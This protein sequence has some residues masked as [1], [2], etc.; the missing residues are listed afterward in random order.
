MMLVLSLNPKRQRRPNVRLGEIGN[1]SASFACGFPPKTKGKLGHKKWK[2][3]FVNQEEI[4]HDPICGF[5]EQRSPKYTASEP[6]FSLKM[7]AD[8]QQNRENK[9]PNSTK[10]ASE[11]ASSDECDMAKSGLDFG[12]ITR[13]CRVMKRRCRN[14]R[15]NNSVFYTAWSSKLNA[16]FD[17]EDAREFGGKECIGFESNTYTNHFPDNGFKDFLDVETPA[18]GKEAREYDMCEPVSDTGQPGYLSQDCNEDACS[19]GNNAFPESGGVWDEM[20]YGGNDVHSVKRWLEELGFGKYA[21]VFEMHEVDE[22]ALLLLTLEDL[23]EMG[24]FAVGPRRKLYTAIQQL[25]G[26][27]VSA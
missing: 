5:S 10:M 12:P 13:K 26:E 20:V 19:E 3:D 17:S 16:K 15:T 1:V 22:E 18:A 21:G 24:L 14:T 4:E 11:F 25:R 7:A 23:K 2:D 9:N 6:G 27:D 8:L